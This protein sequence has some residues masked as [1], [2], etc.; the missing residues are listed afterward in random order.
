[1]IKEIPI[2]IIVYKDK[3]V[4]KEVEVEKIV[5][6]L[7]PTIKEVPNYI[8]RIVCKTVYRL[9]NCAILLMVLFD[10]PCT[11]WFI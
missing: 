9:P 8:D 1:M 3:I 11:A 6:R 2:E 4:T 7:V 10:T 5:E